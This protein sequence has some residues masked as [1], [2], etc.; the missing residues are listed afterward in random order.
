MCLAL[1]R[2]ADWQRESPSSAFDAPRF[3]SDLQL[4]CD[5]VDALPMLHLTLTPTLPR[6]LTLTLTLTLTRTRARTRSQAPARAPTRWR[7]S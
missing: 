1:L 6:T 5:G 3:E 2:F 7:H 4:L